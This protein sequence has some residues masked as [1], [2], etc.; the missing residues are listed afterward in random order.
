MAECTSYIEY[1]QGGPGSFMV[2]D[3]LIYR[4]VGIANKCPKCGKSMYLSLNASNIANQDLP[5]WKIVTRHPLTLLPSIEHKEC[6]WHG[7]LTAGEFVPV[8]Q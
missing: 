3:S 5:T 4:C 6:N 2:L 7:Y 1:E 8:N